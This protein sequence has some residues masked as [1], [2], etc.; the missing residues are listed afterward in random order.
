MCACGCFLVAAIVGGLAYCVM[1]ALWL[2]AAG[3]VVFAGIIGWLGRK[4]AA[5]RKPKA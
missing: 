2:P 3:L 4:A 1:H 5:T